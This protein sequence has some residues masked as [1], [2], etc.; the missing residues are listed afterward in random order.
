M[1][2]QANQTVRK[3]YYRSTR[4]DVTELKRK[5]YQRKAACLKYAGTPGQKPGQQ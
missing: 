2:K 4:Q 5:F 3:K 1:D